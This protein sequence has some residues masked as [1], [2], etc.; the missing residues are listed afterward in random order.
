[1]YP[2]GIY[3]NYFVDMSIVPEFTNN[4]YNLAT[5]I[6]LFLKM[7]SFSF[8]LINDLDNLFQNIIYA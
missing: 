4:N 5:K 8:K 3:I 7:K 2:E 1:M 6:W